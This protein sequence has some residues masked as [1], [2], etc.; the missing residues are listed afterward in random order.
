MRD[1]MATKESIHGMCSHLSLQTLMTT[2]GY[3]ERVRVVNEHA[4]WWNKRR[5]SRLCVASGTL[6]EIVVCLGDTLHGCRNLSH[7]PSI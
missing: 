5:Q 1:S 7:C 4:T 3:E 6:A 2:M